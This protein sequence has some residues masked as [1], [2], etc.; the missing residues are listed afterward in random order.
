[1]EFLYPP[2]VAAPGSQVVGEG[3]GAGR[4]GLGAQL[5]HLLPLLGVEQEVPRVK[6]DLVQLLLPRGERRH[7]GTDRGSEGGEEKTA[8]GEGKEEFGELRNPGQDSED[9]FECPWQSS[10]GPHTARMD[11]LLSEA[12]GDAPSDPRDLQQ[13]GNVILWCCLCSRGTNS[14]RRDNSNSRAGICDPAGAHGKL[15]VNI[16]N[17]PAHSHRH[18]GGIM[19]LWNYGA[20]WV[21]R[22]LKTTQI[23]PLLGRDDSHYCRAFYKILSNLLAAGKSEGNKIF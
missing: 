10:G 23:H 19:E 20:V 16:F 9:E 15:A 5:A 8:P 14:H 1:M 4:A 13:A 22:D 18:W 21:G 17:L 11:L 6:H 3:F 7:L 12:L 2:S